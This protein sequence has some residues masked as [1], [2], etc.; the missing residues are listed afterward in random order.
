MAVIPGSTSQSEFQFS[1]WK[2]NA[3]G[4]IGLL[5][6]S[7]CS[8]MSW[9][10]GETFVSFWFLPFILLSIPV[11]M[12]PGTIRC[13]QKKIAQRSL[14]GSFEMEWDDIK[15][16]KEGQSNLAFIDGERRLCLPLPVWCSRKNRG[17]FL[18]AL[19][20]FI[21]ERD[22]EVTPSFLV[23]FQFSKGTRIE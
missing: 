3:V 15:Q 2:L 11:F 22:L 20:T 13:N 17:K 12:Q 4:W 21:E 6:F 1:L 9:Q 23:D 14:L 18:L 5:F 19:E 10:A 7:F 8:F 16:I